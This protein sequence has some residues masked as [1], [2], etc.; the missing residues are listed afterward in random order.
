MI[1]VRVI[2]WIARLAGLGALLLGLLFWIAQVDLITFH[3]LF[4]LTLGLSLLVLSLIMVFSKG[5]RLLGAAGIVYAFIL[6]IFGLTQSRLLIGNLHWLIQA[7]HLLVGLGALALV[8]VIYTRYERLKTA[9]P[10]MVLPQ[11]VR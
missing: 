3:M 6:P 7:A 11:A 4:G 9:T 5:M 1:A 2:V 10:E 8:Q